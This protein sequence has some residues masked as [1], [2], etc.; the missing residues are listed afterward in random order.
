MQYTTRS[1]KL[2]YDIQFA[3]ASATRRSLDIVSELE[4]DNIIVP[5][6]V[7]LWNYLYEN[8]HIQG[9][10]HEIQ[11]VVGKKMKDV[12][13][14]I[15]LSDDSSDVYVQFIIRSDNYTDDII[16]TIEEISQKMIFPDILVTTDFKKA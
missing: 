1:D 8:Y 13:T 15:E 12:T 14:T 3:P 10:L 11:Y 16:N 6:S 4:D 7:K 9:H 2:G 5:I